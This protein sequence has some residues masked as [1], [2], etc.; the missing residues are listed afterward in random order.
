MN[1]PSN[2]P[3]PR[4]NL[5]VATRDGFRVN[6]HLG[7]ARSLRIY[8]PGPQGP[9]FLEERPAPP[10]GGGAERWQA[11]AASLEDCSALLV[12]GVGGSPRRALEEAGLDVLVLEGSIYEALG[13]L[14]AGQ[15]PGRLE[16]LTPFKCGESCE[17]AGKG[18]GA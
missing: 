18:C 7:E 17:G 9:V 4:L 10:P 1:P 14:F 6:A 15:G 8:Q 13:A 2:P 5:A 12:N 11:L 16:K 3:P